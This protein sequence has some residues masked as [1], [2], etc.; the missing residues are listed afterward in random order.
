MIIFDLQ[1]LAM[2]NVTEND[3]VRFNKGKFGKIV[4]FRTIK[5]KT[6]SCKYPDMSNIIPSKNQTKGRERFAKAVK[7]AKVAMNDPAQR[8]IYEK[9]QAHSPYHAA[10]KDFLNKFKEDKPAK[11][12]QTPAQMAAL[13]K[14]A[15]N[16]G[17]LKAIAHIVKK[18]ILTNGVYQKMNNVSKATATRH[19]QEMV[20]FKLIQSNLVKGA[21]A[22][23]IKGSWWTKK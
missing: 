23:Y 1:T 13:S 21:G 6:F 20:N 2:S 11:V 4:V 14:L 3:L 15:L 18:G 8:A 10:V 7:F 9:M 22:N 16:S 17:Q 5:G 19:L 12:R